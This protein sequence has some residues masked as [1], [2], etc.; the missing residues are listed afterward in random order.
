ML[1]EQ[2]L[3][4][5]QNQDYPRFLCLFSTANICIFALR[6]IRESGKYGIKVMQTFVKPSLY[7]I[8]K[9]TVTS[10]SVLKFNSVAGG[11][12]AISLLAQ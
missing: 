8:T 6:Y 7:K 5:M 10:K 2:V 9:K 11:G 3:H 4:I 1:V 12:F